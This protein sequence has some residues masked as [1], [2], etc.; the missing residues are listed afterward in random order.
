MAIPPF[1]PH[2][3]TS[4]MAKTEAHAAILLQQSTHSKILW[5]RFNNSFPGALETLKDLAAFHGIDVEKELELLLRE[6]PKEIEIKLRKFK[7]ISKDV[8]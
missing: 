8:E 7:Q 2:D 3:Y 1:P 5:E 6:K 4:F